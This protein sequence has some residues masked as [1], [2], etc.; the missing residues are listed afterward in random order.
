MGVPRW[1]SVAKWTP[2]GTVALFARAK[3]SIRTTWHGVSQRKRR[4][5][6]TSK[7]S[8]T[9]AGTI[10]DM[11]EL[12]ARIAQRRAELGLLDLP[13]NSGKNRTASNRVAQGD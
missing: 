8:S 12:G 11:A 6:M 3:G 5:A 10:I 7:T 1:P 13:R 4:A 2:E 9:E